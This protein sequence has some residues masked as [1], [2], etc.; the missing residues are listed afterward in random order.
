MLLGTSVL[1]N[2]GEVLST[3]EGTLLVVS[4]RVPTW[5]YSL[6]LLISRYAHAWEKH[7]EESEKNCII[8]CLLAPFMWGVEF[9]VPKLG[10]GV[11]SLQASESHQ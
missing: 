2:R 6:T 8:G 11:H 4:H 3:V 1:L 10:F 5:S 7:W 9:A